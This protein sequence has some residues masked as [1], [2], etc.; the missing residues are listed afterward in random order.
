M[1][2]WQ[3]FPRNK[4]TIE[5]LR[6]VTQCFTKLEPEISSKKHNYHSNEIL[7]KLREPLEAI[8]FKVETGKKKK[9]KITIPVLFGRNGKPVK[10]FDVD[11]F[12]EETKTVLEVEAGRGVMNNQFLKD[13]FEACVMVDVEYLILA[14]RND[15]KERKDFETVATFFDTTYASGRLKIPLEGILVIGY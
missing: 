2:A 10:W 9:E 8:G 13:F 6:K 3:F 5:V 11:A 15:Y 4:Q 12:H 1:I 7:E 14:I